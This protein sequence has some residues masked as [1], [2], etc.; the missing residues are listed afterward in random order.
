[1][2]H[3][4]WK[5]R[6]E[7]LIRSNIYLYQFS[8]YLAGRFLYRIAHEVDF[9][10]FKFLASRNGIFLDVGANDGISALT[11][12]IYN[13]KT[14]IVSIEP[15]PYHRMA[16]ER[17]KRRLHGF[18]YICIGAGE[19]KDS[20]I[21]H[22]PFYK[23]V[24]LTSFASV[25]KEAIKKGLLRGMRIKNIDRK[26]RFKQIKIEIQTLDTFRFNPDFI[27][28]DV[29]GHEDKVLQGLSE[30]INLEKPT[31][32]IECNQDTIDSVVCFLESFEYR[33]F[34]YRSEIQEFHYYPEEETRN[35]F[36]IHPS[37]FTDV[38][39]PLG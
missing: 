29:E 8:R 24:A 21:L 7:N 5:E 10:A 4:W 15:N 32:L 31:I 30:T 13:K 28:I 33:K 34:I 36:F 39:C 37:R 3:V 16:L 19:R 20:V 18:D 23:G 2:P 14:P 12:R 38:R 26:V 17:V 9:E 25:H 35:I 6:V 27:K 1:M 22:V 11:F